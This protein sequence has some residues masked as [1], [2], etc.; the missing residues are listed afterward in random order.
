MG[1]HAL[2]LTLLLGTSLHSK[3]LW[4]GC[5]L[6]TSVFLVGISF[7]ML[8]G[9][10][11]RQR[12][13]LGGSLF[14]LALTQHLNHAYIQRY[15]RRWVVSSSD[16]NNQDTLG[17][18]NSREGLHRSDPGLLLFWYWLW[19]RRVV[20]IAPKVWERVVRS[21]ENQLTLSNL[22]MLQ[23]LK[24]QLKSKASPMTSPLVQ[25]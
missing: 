9:V 20:E 19:W 11:R 8:I 1:Q 3:F 6:L 23:G 17:F 4:V 24:A 7:K 21:G 2:S 16:W 10:W 15:L 5:F 25:A 18:K 22:G 14:C 13:S 12:C